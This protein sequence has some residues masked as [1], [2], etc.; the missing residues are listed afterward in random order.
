ME[1]DGNEDDDKSHR[2]KTEMEDH[3]TQDESVWWTIVKTNKLEIEGRVE[4][5]QIS[6]QNAIDLPFNATLHR[7]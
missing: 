3:I 1:K 6:A 2:H 5:G 7:K 4:G